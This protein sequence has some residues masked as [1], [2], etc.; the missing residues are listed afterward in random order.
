MA[1]PSQYQFVSL[2][3][4]WIGNLFCKIALSGYVVILLLVFLPQVMQHGTNIKSALIVV[5]GNQPVKCTGSALLLAKRSKSAG[6]LGY[7]DI[8]FIVRFLEN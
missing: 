5:D 4:K 1:I 7:K 2:F 3:S 6:K 8:N